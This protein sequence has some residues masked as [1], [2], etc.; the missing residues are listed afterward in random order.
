[1]LYL[2]LLII[3]PL[4]CMKASILGLGEIAQLG[5]LAAL[6][7][8]HRFDSQHLHGSLQP[9]LTLAPGDSTLYFCF[10]PHHT[11]TQYKHTDRQTTNVDKTMKKFWVCIFIILKQSFFLFLFYI[12]IPVPSPSPRSS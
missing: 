9:S 1:M 6:P 7:R 3:C 2:F 5:T 10:Y 11:H 12:Q 4:L 8:E